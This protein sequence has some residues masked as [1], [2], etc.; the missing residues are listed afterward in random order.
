MRLLIG[1]R[2]GPVYIGTSFP[3]HPARVLL[4]H[5]ADPV[6]APIAWLILFSC[7]NFSCWRSFGLRDRISQ[8][9]GRHENRS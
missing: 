1:K 2:V 3:M 6:P 9:K 5:G 8:G 7:G 4:H